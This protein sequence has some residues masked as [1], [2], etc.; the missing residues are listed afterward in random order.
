MLMNNFDSAAQEGASYRVIPTNTQPNAEANPRR[1]PKKGE[2]LRPDQQTPCQ[3]TTGDKAPHTP[4]ECALQDSWH[5]GTNY[6]MINRQAKLIELQRKR[7]GNKMTTDD[8]KPASSSSTPA[9]PRRT[10]GVTSA[11][12][13]R[14]R[15]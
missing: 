5:H 3:Y 6:M 13:Y 9:N 2:R 10:R 15:H 1:P 8:D 11:M 12:A 7:A 14:G 4:I